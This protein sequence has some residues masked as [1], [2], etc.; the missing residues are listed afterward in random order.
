MDEFEKK[1]VRGELWDEY[2]KAPRYSWLV[3]GSKVKVWLLFTIAFDKWVSSHP[4]YNKEECFKYVANFITKEA[5]RISR[6]GRVLIG[7][8]DEEQV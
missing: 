7:S 6:E 5:M 2:V 8:S 1:S 3:I 4:E